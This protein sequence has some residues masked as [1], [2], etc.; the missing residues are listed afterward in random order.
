MC[1]FNVIFSYEEFIFDSNDK[2]ETY[3]VKNLILEL[4][5]EIPL[6]DYLMIK[7]FGKESEAVPHII[8]YCKTDSSDTRIQLSHNPGDVNYIWLTKK[9]VEE[10]KYIKVTTPLDDKTYRLQ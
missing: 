6:K 1:L 10:G 7:V 5:I 8:E 9:Q 2:T 3:S 4:K